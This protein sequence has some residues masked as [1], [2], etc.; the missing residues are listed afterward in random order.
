M[1]EA[2]HLQKNLFHF[3]GTTLHGLQKD[4]DINPDEYLVF[5]HDIDYTVIPKNPTLAKQLQALKGKKFI[6]TNGPYNHAIQ[7]LEQIGIVDIFDGI[8]DIKQANYEPKPM[9]H[10]YDKML[11]A[12][13]IKDASSAIMLDDIAKNLVPASKLGMKTVLVEAGLEYSA[14]ECDAYLDYKIEH[15]CDFLDEVLTS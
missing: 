5:T 15:L 9:P 7:T 3:H 8:F 12:L 4:Y 11:A 1:N 14:E 13:Q 10:I 6:F 2:R